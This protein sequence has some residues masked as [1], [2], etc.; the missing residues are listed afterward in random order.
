[1]S[2][3]LYYAW[4]L[5]HG[6]SCWTSFQKNSIGSK[7]GWNAYHVT[8]CVPATGIHRKTRLCGRKLKIKCWWQNEMPSCAFGNAAALGRNRTPI[9]ACVW[10]QNWGIWSLD[11]WSNL[12][13]SGSFSFLRQIHKQCLDCMIAKKTLNPV[14]K[15]RKPLWILWSF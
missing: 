3:V 7:S 2:L 12:L 5:S 10:M 15:G 4:D 1:M 13:L 11:C 9:L 8:L 6:I 14:Y